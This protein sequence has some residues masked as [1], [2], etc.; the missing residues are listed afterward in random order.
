LL[1]D[2]LQVLDVIS[3][4]NPFG[5]VL[6]FPRAIIVP[7]GGIMR[8]KERL[9]SKVTAKSARQGS[10]VHIMG[11][12][13]EIDATTVHLGNTGETIPRSEVTSREGYRRC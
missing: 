5:L 9:A 2:A 13:L 1:L 3:T 11:L 10:R 4:L 8:A 7:Q 6:Q 12:K